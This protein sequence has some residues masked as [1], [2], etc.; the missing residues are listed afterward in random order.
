MQSLAGTMWRL[1]EA[2]AFNEEGRELPPPF[3]PSPMGFGMFDG[4]RMIT[5]VSDGR[6]SLPPDVQSRAFIAYTGKY[7][8][9]GAKLVV[10][11]DGASSPDV[12]KEQIRHIR[13]ESPTRVCITPENTV[14]GQA[15]LKVVYERVG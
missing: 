1:I 4:E 2:S 7:H 12:A 9:D 3:G 8:F 15:G 13:F 6:H 11:V 10:T 5:A 14:L